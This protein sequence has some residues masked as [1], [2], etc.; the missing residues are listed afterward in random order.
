MVSECGWTGDCGRGRGIF[1]AN[2]RPCALRNRGRARC[3]RTIVKNARFYEGVHEGVGRR[4]SG[5]REGTD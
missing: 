2:G 4:D 5:G 1:L 3:T